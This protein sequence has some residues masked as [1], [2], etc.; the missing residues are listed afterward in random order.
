MPPPPP[1]RRRSPLRWCFRWG[2]CVSVVTLLLLV[3]AF[4]YLSE[5]GLP[6]FVETRL[7][8]ALHTRGIELEFSQLRFHW[9]RGL[10][11]EDV[12]LAGT[13]QPQRAEFWAREI[14]LEPSIPSLLRGRIDLAGAEAVDGRVL[15]PLTSNEGTQETLTIDHIDAVAELGPGDDLR[16]TRLEADMLGVRLHLTGSLTNVSALGRS[17]DRA[18]SGTLSPSWPAETRRFVRTV[19]SLRFSQAPE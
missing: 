7:L 12:T 3:G 11:A 8:Q 5:V 16:V 17:L 9:F 18:P 1:R 19:R 4:V 6:D 2:F 14:A 10:V 13:R 15:L